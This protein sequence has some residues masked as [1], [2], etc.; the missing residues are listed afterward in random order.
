MRIIPRMLPMTSLL[1]GAYWG[2]VFV[3]FLAA[4][5]PPNLGRFPF[6]Q[7]TDQSAGWVAAVIGVLLV[8]SLSRDA[9]AR[10]LEV[11][12]AVVLGCVVAYLVVL[13][14]GAALLGW[15]IGVESA[16][17]RN[18]QYLHV[19]MNANAGIP[20]VAYAVRSS[21]ILARSP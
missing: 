12:L 2:T 15:M 11:R 4:T 10:P 14:P 19:I 21:R 8:I 9:F 3:F 17:G 20:L 16:S 13:Q 5:L 18:P 1:P 7:P 6:S